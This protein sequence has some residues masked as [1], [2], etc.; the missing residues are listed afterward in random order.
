M[1]RSARDMVAP[2]IRMKRLCMERGFGDKWRDDTA[3][4]VGRL[5]S[6]GGTLLMAQTKG[7]TIEQRDLWDEGVAS[8]QPQPVNERQ[9][10]AG[11]SF[12]SGTGLRSCCHATGVLFSSAWREACQRGSETSESVP[13]IHSAN[14]VDDVPGGNAK[15]FEQLV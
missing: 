2:S 4:R 9:Q 7:Q 15:R 3:W 13:S 10:K 11:H 8:L 14:C 12:H 6:E 5:A 1:R